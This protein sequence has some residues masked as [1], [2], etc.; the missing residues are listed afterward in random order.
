MNARHNAHARLSRA[1][2]LDA[3]ERA[4]GQVSREL[5]EKHPELGQHY[6]MKRSEM[7]AVDRAAQL[8]QDRTP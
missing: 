8:R 2:T 4:W 6:A 1:D 7:L 3:L 5:R